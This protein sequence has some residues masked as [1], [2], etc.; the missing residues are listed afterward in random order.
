MP[1][2]FHVALRATRRYAF[3]ALIFFIF[4]FDACLR[5]MFMNI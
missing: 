5:D 4:Q 1:I 3:D 2:I